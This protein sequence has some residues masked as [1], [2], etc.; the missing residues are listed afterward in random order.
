[1]TTVSI[2]GTDFVVDGA[3]VNRGRTVRGIPVD[4]LLLNSRMINGIFDDVNPETRGMWAYPDT[5]EWDAERNVS[6]FLAAMPLWR[7]R[8]LDAF[9]IGMQGGSPQ[10][11]SETQPWDSGAFDADGAARPAFFERLRRILDEADRLGFVVIV[12]YFYWGQS[13]RFVNEA[14]ICR[15]ADEATDFLLDGPWRNVLVEVVNECNLPEL[16]DVTPLLR[17]DRVHELIARVQGRQ[18]DGRRLLVS[19]SFAAV[20]PG[21]TDAVIETSDWVLLHGNGTE[22]R[23]VLAAMVEKVRQSPAFRSVPIM[24]NED[25]HFGFDQK[26]NHMTVA[27]KAGASWGY[28]DPGSETVFPPTP[29][30]GNYL[31]GYQAVPIDWQ[32]RTETK[33]AFFDAIA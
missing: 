6:E 4:G 22:S 32:I 27:L 28:F 16:F 10:G 20:E 2:A 25:D 18:R 21:T 8:G 26:E 3:V 29:T 11:Y 15:A 24:F 31:D 1:M 7:E 19:T 9:T 14:A 5:G 23:N 33:R 17:W 13:Q 30:V 12:N